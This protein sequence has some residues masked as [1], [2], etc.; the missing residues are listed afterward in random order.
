M[1]LISAISKWSEWGQ[2][3]HTA[4]YGPINTFKNGK[5]LKSHSYDWLQVL[6]VL[7]KS[8]VIFNFLCWLLSLVGDEALKMWDIWVHVIEKSVGMQNSFPQCCKATLW[9]YPWMYVYFFNTEHTQVR[10]RMFVSSVPKPTPHQAICVN[11]NEQCTVQ[12]TSVYVNLTLGIIRVDSILRCVF[13]IV[14]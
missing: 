3:A 11:T 14:G 2:L 9:I 4:N 5:L 12:K 13:S 6:F 8:H 10:S 7:C 1:F